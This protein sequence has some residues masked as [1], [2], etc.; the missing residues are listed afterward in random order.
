MKAFVTGG[1]GFIGQ[2]LVIKLLERGYDVV[3]LAR[4]DGSARLLQEMGATVARGDITDTASMREG[5]AGSD[6][7]FHL[8][9]WYEI[10]SKDWAKAEMIN[11]GGT[12]KVLRLAHELSVPKIVYTSTVAVFGDTN[13]K[14]VDESYFK[15]GPFLTEY[16]RTKWL[17]HYKVAVPMMEKGA[18]IIIVQPGPAYGPGDHSLIGQ[19]MEAFYRG[20]MPVVF[21][22]DSTVTYAHVEDIAEGIILAAEKACKHSSG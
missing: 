1:T 8:A 9:A 14:L 15:G 18:P 21:G 6:V 10:G 11:V 17:A 22:P 2:H 4:S 16:D 20:Q 12:R 13:G 3:A 19:Q 7:V 5:M